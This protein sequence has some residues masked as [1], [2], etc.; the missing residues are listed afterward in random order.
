MEPKPPTLKWPVAI[1]IALV[2]ASA[3]S[4]R[5]LVGTATM[6]IP[7]QPPESPPV[8]L[9]LECVDSRTIR[10]EITNVG[11]SDTA[12]PL[13]SA[14]ANGRIYMI[15][16]HHLR[17]KRSNGEGADYNYWPAHYPVAIAGRVDPWFQALPVHAAYRMSAKA[18]DFFSL[19]RQPSFRLEPS[20]RSAGQCL[21]R[22]R[23]L[24]S[25]SSSGRELLYRTPAPRFDAS[26]VS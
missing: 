9:T 26:Q 6:S 1:A 18:E 22:P 20:C 11:T 12:L 5:S 23:S 3:L 10:F 17:V 25:L 21:R 15:N 13:G 7:I 4:T 8:T 14:L 16:D 24:Y 19:G 2:V